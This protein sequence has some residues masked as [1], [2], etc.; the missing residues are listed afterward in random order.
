MYILFE[1]IDTKQMLSIDSPQIGLI[2]KLLFLRIPLQDR[3]ETNYL[4]PML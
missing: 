4:P 2:L 1:E 3:Y